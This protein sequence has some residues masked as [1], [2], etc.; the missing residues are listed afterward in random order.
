MENKVAPESIEGLR[1]EYSE[2]NQN[3]RHYS[4]L[5]F[6]MLT[7]YFAI[8]AGLVSVAFDTT[9][10][11]ASSISWFAQL[12]GLLITLIFFM[13]ELIVERFLVHF[14]RV[15]TQLEQELGY[16][17]F[18]TKPRSNVLKTHNATWSLF[19]LLALFWTYVLIT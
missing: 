4:A 17:Q 11:S 16:S 13:F 15:A 1:H 14:S 9:Q 18:S 10:P 3:F 5:R 7:V 8:I 6:A 12:G 19:I 2:V